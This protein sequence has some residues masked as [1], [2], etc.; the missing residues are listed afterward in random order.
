MTNRHVVSR[1][2][3]PVRSGQVIDDFALAFKVL[4]AI[5]AAAVVFSEPVFAARSTDGALNSTTSSRAAWPQTLPPHRRELLQFAFADDITGAVVKQL[6][7]GT[8]ECNRLDPV[9]RI[10]C[11]RQVYSRAAGATGNRPD[12]SGANSALR[13]LSRQLNGIV[14]QN[15]DRKA[16]KAKVGG[17][18]YRAVTRD[19]LRKANQLSSQAI[20]ET[21]TK[22]LRSAGNSKKRKVHYARIANAVNSTKKILRS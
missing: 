21:R 16:A 18:S 3:V 14:R 20:Q 1:S 2:P 5:F 12:Y 17:R 11:L 19:A 15:L 13:S 6:Q 10:D 9:Y 4:I 22:L 8:A 7:R